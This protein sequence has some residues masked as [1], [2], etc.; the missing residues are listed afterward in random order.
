MNIKPRA[1]IDNKLKIPRFFH[2]I[3]VIIQKKYTFATG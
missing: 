3:Y 2:E 1:K